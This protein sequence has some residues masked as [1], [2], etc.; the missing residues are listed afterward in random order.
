[1]AKPLTLY[2]GRVEENLLLEYR[3]MVEQYESV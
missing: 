1:M 3:H 2:P